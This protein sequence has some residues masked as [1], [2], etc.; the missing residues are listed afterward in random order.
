MDRARIAAFLEKFVGYA[1]GATTV[2][3]LAVADRAGLLTWL[4]EHMSGTSSEIAA[5]ADLDERYVRE[6]LSGLAAAG[7][8]EYG[9]DSETFTLPPEHALFLADASSPYF[10]G[11]WMDMIPTL[12]E[13]IDGVTQATRHGGGVRYEEFGSGMIRG[14]DR[15]N[16]PSQTV[17]LVERWLPAVPGLVDRLTSGIRVADVGCGSGTVPIL[18]AKAFPNAEVTGFDVSDDAL[19]VARSRGRSVSNV[20]FENY[21]ADGIPLDPPFDLITAFDVIHDLADPLA[22][23]ERIHDALSPDGVF[24]MMEPNVSSEL[25][26]NLHDIGALMYGISTLHCMTQSLAVGGEGVGAAWGREMAEDHATR[27]GFSTFRPLEDINN[28]FSAFYLLRP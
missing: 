3:L 20:T 15:G 13:Q 11:G 19:G 14:I 22:A 16:S 1:S 21:P 10:M 23:L 6:I 25:E 24:F 2:G 28:K 18:V 17:F 9:S 7:V 26:N 5:G 4:G 27:A 12:F 8:I